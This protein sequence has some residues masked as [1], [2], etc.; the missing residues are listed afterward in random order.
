MFSYICT[1]VICQ[2]LH[3]DIVV[4]L[5]E[6][7][8]HHMRVMTCRRNMISDEKWISCSKTL[9]NFVN[10]SQLAYF[11]VNLLVIKWTFCIDFG[12]CGSWE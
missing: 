1:C 10:V 8:Q 11:D 5:L 4:K 12:Y 2:L 7:L 9:G 3:Y 6:V